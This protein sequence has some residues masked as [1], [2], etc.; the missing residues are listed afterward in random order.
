MTRVKFYVRIHVL[1][2]HLYDIL[3]M[4]NYYRSHFIHLQMSAYGY[5]SYARYNILDIKYR[6]FL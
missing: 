6:K 5:N 4:R 2:I 1:E 3:G